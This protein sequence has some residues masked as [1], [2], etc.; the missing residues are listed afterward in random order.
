MGEV[1]LILAMKKWMTEMVF[2][3]CQESNGEVQSDA[4]DK[5]IGR[6]QSCYTWIVRL[7]TFVYFL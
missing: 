7:L 2:P 4:D 1:L 3:T 6:E 5:K